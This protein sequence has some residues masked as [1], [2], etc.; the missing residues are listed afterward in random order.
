MLNLEDLQA[1][2]QYAGAYHEEQDMIL[3]LWQVRLWPLCSSLRAQRL[4]VS[5]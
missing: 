3:A 2:A 1:H 4:H 5:L